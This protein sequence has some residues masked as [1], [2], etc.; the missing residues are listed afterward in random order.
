ALN[1]AVERGE[2]LATELATVKAR[3]GE[4]TP[5]AALEPFAAPGV[6]HPAVLAREFSDLGPSLQASAAPREGVLGKL[7]MNAEKLIRIRR[8]DETPG[9]DPA[10]ILARS[11]AKVLRGDIAGGLAE[12]AQLPPQARMPAE[13]WI[14]RA[15]AA[16]AAPD[17]CPPRVGRG[18]E[19]GGEAFWGGG[20]GRG[21]QAGFFPPPAGG[22]GVGGG[23][24]SRFAR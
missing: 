22:G 7:Q 13:A 6:P 14:K 4:Q 10:A 16:V 21:R 18:G 11:E 19:V 23:H 5:P 9:S 17:A 1:G 12:L 24:A 15:Q 2:P 8:I 20:K 3:G